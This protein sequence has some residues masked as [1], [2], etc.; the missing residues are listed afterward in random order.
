MSGT[1][2]IVHAGNLSGVVNDNGLDPETVYY[3]AIFGF[4]GASGP[5]F[6]YNI[7]SPLTGSASTLSDEPTD[8]PSNMTFSGTTT[9]STLLSFTAATSAPTG[10]LI[11]RRIGA[12]PTLVP[13]DGT[14]Y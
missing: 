10:Y 3:Y 9:S 13:V 7:A 14:T 6:N 1:T 5:T 11:V 4:N 12:A 2:T 8:G